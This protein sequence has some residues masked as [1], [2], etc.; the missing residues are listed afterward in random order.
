MISSPLRAVKRF[1]KKKWPYLRVGMAI[2]VPERVHHAG[3]ARRQLK[4]FC[5]LCQ[6]VE[7]FL[8]ITSILA[9]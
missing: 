6:Q 8:Q 4:L 9:H 3:I 5:F 1:F 2:K 7:P